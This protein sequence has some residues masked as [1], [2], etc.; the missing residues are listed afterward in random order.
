M[1]TGWFA[2]LAAAVMSVGVH[3]QGLSVK[4]PGVPVLVGVEASID[5]MATGVV[6]GGAPSI[7]V[8]DFDLVFDPALLEIVSVQ[9]GSGLDVLGLGAIDS[10]L[11]GTGTVN[12]L[13]LS[14][15]TVEDLHALQPDEFSLATVTFLTLAAGTSALE[16]TVNAVGDAF[17]EP[18]PITVTNGEIAIVA[19]PEPASVVL[20]AGGLALVGGAIGRRARRLNRSPA[21]A[22]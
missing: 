3:A 9:F 12:L 15:D 16:V 20:M 7:G 1:R 13:Q 2:L 5:V 14:L 18:I 21:Q 4:A 17:G 6:D 8:F 11:T 22:S 10:V 19:V